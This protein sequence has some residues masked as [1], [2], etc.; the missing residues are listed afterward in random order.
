MRP[1]PIAP[2]WL[3]ILLF[4]ASLHCVE[5][6]ILSASKLSAHLINNF[7]V[8][9]SNM[10]SGH[11]RVLKVLGL[12][13]GFPSGMVQAMRD[14]KARVPNGKLVVRI[15]SPRTYSLANDATASA[16]DFWN[17]ILQQ[18]LNYL[19]PSDRALIDY[20]EGPNEGQTPTLGYPNATAQQALQASQWFN[21]FWTNLTPLIVAD[22]YRPCIASIAVGNPGGTQAQMQSY[23][24]A[25]VPALRQAQAAGGAWSYHAYTIDYTTDPADEIWYSLRYRQFYSFFAGSY[26]DLN[27]MPLILTEG[28]VDQTGNPATSGWQARGPASYYQRWLNWFDRQIQQDSYVLGCTLFENGDS[29]G[30]PSFELEPI[31]GWLGNYLAGPSALPPPPTT[32][33][34]T[35][36]NGGIALAWTNI[37]LTP[38]AWNV[39][40]ATNSAGPFF[41]LATNLTAGVASTTYTDTNVT[42]YNAYYYVITVVNAAGEGDPSTPVSAMPTAPAYSA[43]N[44]G[45]STLGAYSADAFFDTGN[46]YIT[47][48]AINTN[49]LSAPAPMAVYQS[50]R[51]GNMTYSFTYL[52]PGTSYKVRLHF[53]EVYWTSVGQR[54]F[55]VLIN[56]VQ[57][58][59]NFDI[60]A[61]SG[62]AYRG[63][64][65]EFNAIS[66][67]TGRLSVQIVT[68]TDNASING[69]ELLANST[70][71]VP[72]APANLAATVSSGLVTLTW[73]VPPGASSF[74][75]KR[76]TTSGG[77]YSMSAS[78]LTQAMYRDPSCTPGTTYYYVVAALNALGESAPSAQV[79]GRTI[80]ALPDLVITSV[81]WSPTNLYNG[82][83]AVFSAR[84]LNRGAASTPGG[85]KIGTAFIVD[86]SEVSWSGNYTTAL[87]ANGVVTLIAD[88]G[89]LGVNYWTATTGPHTLTALVD[90]LNLISE[91]IEDNNTT[92]TSF[93]VFAAGYAYNSG[94]G[95]VGSFAADDN[96]GGSL[97]TFAVTNGID[98]SGSPNPAP[99]A[100]YQSERWGEFAYL[101]GN[102]TPGSN[103]T[104]RLHF[105][106]I[107]SSVTNPGD[108]RFNISINGIQVFTDFDVLAGAGARF[109]ATSRD[110]KKRA[111]SSG[112]LLVQFWHG[113]ANQPKCNGIE[114]FGS[115]PVT[116]PPQ[117]I[118]FGVSNSMAVFTYQTSPAA[119]YQVQYKNDLN[120]PNWL[121]LGNPVI[122]SGTTLT[123]S[124]PLINNSRRFYRVVQFN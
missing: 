101:L 80:S 124:D 122:A 52:A 16:S 61:A 32:V 88:G 59:T 28:G 79:S 33:S 20:L 6:Q 42:N 119:I 15:Y 54:V 123:A 55:N 36:G 50:Q 9:S 114:V 7:T 104:I 64:I 1:G 81:G 29:G 82:S 97:N 70:N 37:P 11:P 38:T 69:I 49:G 76:S 99:A 8:G 113:S 65:Q 24:A 100:V 39:K 102:L 85:T 27:N 31:A 43:F 117:V 58:L 111:D 4:S 87:P 90:D 103:Y 98:L 106:E 48:T 18:G 67:Q 84:V 13:S 56:G 86:G 96:F 45:G 51:Y 40:R 53:A 116:Q 19:S 121:N 12:D 71:S 2:Q 91:G 35:P 46:T 95:A 57:V 21:Q 72:A 112:N 66:D 34:A 74:A 118:G 62:A 44:C 120:G 94:G 3:A 60:I 105:A 93:S 75:V 68:V 10:V 30:W 92:A 23:L 110:I 83:H 47:G 78:N 77:P 109:Q 73:S 17:T 22:G 14:Y 26:P 25:F 89:P 115:T 5:A 108:R 107:S 63:N 41:S